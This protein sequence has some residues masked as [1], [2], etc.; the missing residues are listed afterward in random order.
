MCC[1]PK[2]RLWYKPGRS[3]GSQVKASNAYYWHMHGW[4]SPLRS[5]R[6]IGDLCRMTRQGRIQPHRAPQPRVGLLT[7]IGPVPLA[8]LYETSLIRPDTRQGL[9][10]CATTAEGMHTGKPSK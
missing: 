4:R 8:V 10:E 5:S 2:H 1:G 6:W 3:D 7:A 9:R